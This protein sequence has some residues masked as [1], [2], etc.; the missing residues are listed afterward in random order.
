MS[1]LGPT[2]GVLVLGVFLNT[3]LYGI[4]SYQYM[5]YANTKF[6]DPLWMKVTVLSLFLLDTVHTASLIHMVWHY[7]I[8]H[9]G[10]VAALSNN[11]WG[12]PFTVLVTALIAF[13]TQLFLGYR[14][15]T[16]FETSDTVINRLMRA[17]IQTG[18]LCGICSILALIVFLKKPD[19]QLYGFFGFPISRLYTNYTN[20]KTGAHYADTHGHSFV[21]PIFVRLLGQRQEAV[22]TVTGSLRL[23]VRKDIETE[24]KFDDIAPGS[25]TKLTKGQPSFERISG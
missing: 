21:P 20:T 7:S 6:N 5:A 10:D 11:I 25:Q 15:R 16:G 2:L 18:V 19:T 3:Y 14:S 24:L 12:L 17:T 1:N 13:L 8:S 4:V 23:Q 9:F 22:R